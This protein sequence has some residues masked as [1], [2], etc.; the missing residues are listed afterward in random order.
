MANQD[1]GRAAPA[2]APGSS[3]AAGEAVRHRRL[4]AN[5][6]GMHVAE[7]GSG[8]LVVLLHG[9]PELWYSWRHQL[10]VLAA[11][12]YR[13]VAPDLRGY[14]DTDPSAADEGYAPSNMAADIAGLLD[15]LGA[16]R[17]VL[18]GHD[19]GANIAWACAELFPQR[20][21]GLVALSV[22]YRPRPPA[23][24]SEVLRQFLP[25][26]ATASPYPLGVTEAELEADARRSLRL[27]LYAL[28]G[29]APPGLVPRLFQERAPSGR[30]LDS[31]PEPGALPA[32]LSADDLGRYAQAYARTGFWGP[33]GVY[34]NQDRDWHEHP[35]IGTVGVRQPALFIGGRRDPAVLFGKLEPMEAAVPNLRRI[36]LLP[37][38]GHWTQQERPGDVN[39]ELL[40][41][42][43][44]EQHP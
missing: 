4:Q 33:L 41:F 6:I 23:P 5:G 16:E 13:A 8:P 31:M 42:L 24:P 10:P 14:G 28:S 3:P 29:D 19:W 40:A 43:Q 35:E 38:C 25:G 9:F 37:N 34:R 18:A 15:A 1:A 36:V 12:G 2:R 44:R 11:A 22:P 7:A 26:G 39:D 27:F 30:V 20:V 21:A 32:W 17:A